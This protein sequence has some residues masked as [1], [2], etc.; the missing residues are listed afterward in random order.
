MRRL[1]RPRSREIVAATADGKTLIYTDG[2][3]DTIGFI[4]ITN[5]VAPTAA[6]SVPLDPDPADDMD[7]SP[8]SVEV[9][10]NQYALVAVDNERHRRAPRS[11][12]RPVACW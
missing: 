2:D 1:A 4:D 6:G 12:C 3:R 7:Y 8:T 5:P 10:R 9:L 11:S